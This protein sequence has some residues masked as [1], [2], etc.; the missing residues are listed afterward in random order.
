VTTDIQIAYDR[1]KANAQIYDLWWRYYDGDQPLVYTAKRLETAFKN[2]NARF[3]E[4]WCAVVVDSV[5]ERLTLKRFV[6]ENNPAAEKRANELWR[7]T[8]MTLEDVDAHRAAMV[9][10]ESYVMAW[11]D[12][13]MPIE[14]YYHDPRSCYLHYDPEHP[15]QRLWGAKWWNDAGEDGRQHITIY[16]PDKIQYYVSVKKAKDIKTGADFVADESMAQGGEADNPTGK[17]P[18]FH[19]RTERRTIK[20]E[21]AN[22]RTIQDACNKT[23]ND[24]MVAAEFGAY[25]QRYIIGGGDLSGIKAAPDRIMDIPGGDGMGQQVQVGEFSE[26][27][28]SQFLEVLDRLA[29]TIGVIS[30]TPRHY[31]YAQAGTPSG[32]ALI[33]M[34]APLNHKAARYIE[35]FA[36]TWARF[37]SFLLELDG[38]SDVKPADIQVIFDKPETVQP[39]TQ[40][41]IRQINSGA[42]VPIAT[43]LRWEGKDDQEIEAMQDDAADAQVA[44]M[45]NIGAMEAEAARRAAQLTDGQ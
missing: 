14:A 31:F 36:S 22:V 30:R 6:I 4:N 34:E 7:E 12:D 42:G 41:E 40:A 25:K 10:G 19:H 9:C 3:V 24:M 1:L 26:V 20:S 43:S 29:Q 23:L 5:L 11:R 16:Y 18:I 15:R 27:N 13:N 45:P 32:E 21:L 28:L 35:L 37:M 2:V 39:K 17:I 8:E 44:S 33:A 38:I